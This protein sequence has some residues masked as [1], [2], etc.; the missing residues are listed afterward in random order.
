MFLS[1]CAMRIS[2]Q[3][4]KNQSQKCE[5]KTPVHSISGEFSLYF[6]HIFITDWDF[7]TKFGSSDPSFNRSILTLLYLQFETS[8]HAQIEVI[9]Y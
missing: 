1:I 2:T 4:K 3:S 6:V 7:L 5:V 9:H 8:T